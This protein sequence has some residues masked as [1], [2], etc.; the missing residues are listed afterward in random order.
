MIAQTKLTGMVLGVILLLAGLVGPAAAQEESKPGDT[1]CIQCHGSQPGR[2]G[3][4]VK[5]WR[6]SIH[7]ANG[8]SC[9]D[10][11]G[12]D[13]TDFAMAMSPER[14]FLGAPK[15]IAIPDFCGRCH[16]GVKED[17]LASHHGQA[18]G[19]GG[20]QCVTCHSNHSIVKASLDLINQQDCTRCHEFGRAKT[21]KEAM[22]ETDQRLADLTT[23]LAGLQKIGIAVDELQGA[24]FALRN[25]FHRLFHSVDVEQVNQQTSQFQSRAAEIGGKIESIQTDLHQ[26]KLWGAVVA[27]LLFFASALFFLIRKTYQ[28]DEKKRPY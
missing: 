24:T 26:R 16:I 12:G 8:I 4:P 14:G 7:A 1:V 11:H 15:E 3:E 28:D 6:Q 22:V 17:Y 27:V 13:P 21:I 25:D 10:C 5:L 2:L 19:A 20:P 18:L 23:D 9:H